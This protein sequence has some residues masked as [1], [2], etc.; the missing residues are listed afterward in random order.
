LGVCAWISRGIRLTRGS[1]LY[2]FHSVESPKGAVIPLKIGGQIGTYEITALLGKGGMGE[3]YRARDAKLKREVAIKILPEEFSRDADRV[4]RFQREAEVLASLN[5]A[6]IAAIY[7]VQEATGSRFLVLELVEGETLADRIARGP[8]PVEELLPIAKGISEALEAAHEKGVLHRDLKPANIKITPAGRVKVLDFGLAKMFGAEQAASAASNSPT[9]MSLSA[10][11]VILG[12]AAYMSPEQARGQAV[13]A[14]S[15][16][17]AFGCILYEMLTGQQTFSGET[18]TDILGGIVRVDPDWSVLPADTPPLLR[19]LLRQCLQKNRAARLH[20]IAD[21]RIQLEAASAEAP[22]AAAGATIKTGDID[23]RRP[24]G[25]IAVIAAMSLLLIGSAPLAY[26]YLSQT[27]DRAVMRFSFTMPDKVSYGVN[28]LAPF[29]SVSHDG[30]SVAF[31]ALQDGISRVW[32][33]PIDSL[34]PRLLPGTEGALAEFPFWSADDRHLGFFTPGKLKKVDINGGPAQVVCDV[35]AGFGGSWNRDNIIIFSDIVVKRVSSGG[36]IPEPI[37]SLDPKRHEVSHS[38]PAFLPDG[39]HFLF[40]SRTASLETYAVMAGSLN[41]KEIKLVMN[42]NSLVEYDSGHLLF[43][44]DGTLFAQRFDPE[45]QQFLG[46]PFSVAEQIRQN[47]N[48]GLA[49]FSVS[50]G[51]LAY[52]TGNPDGNRRLEWFDRSGKSLG[53]VGM[54]G[55]FRNPELSPDGKRIAVERIDIQTQNDDVWV[56]DVARGIPSRL[57]FDPGID[58]YPVWSPNGEQIAF[59]T[60]RKGTDNLYLT[61]STGGTEELLLKGAAIPRDWTKDN[62]F[63]V[64]GVGAGSQLMV[65]PLSGDRKTFPFLANSGFTYAQARV[66]P[67]GKWLAYYSNESG[68]N[69]IYVQNFPVPTAKFQ[70]STDG[71]VSPRWRRDGTEIFYVSPDNVLMAVSVRTT[72]KTVDPSKSEALFNIGPGPAGLVGYGTRQ[73]YDVTADGKRFLVNS[74]ITQATENPVAVVWNWLGAFSGK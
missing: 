58:M 56:F 9:L 22:P 20:H 71:G 57:T 6:N 13:D 46:D 68:R 45:K 59:G 35:A 49:T 52:R 2:T 40:L 14:Q 29:P 30:K 43:V 44:R 62:R 54:P 61:S 19:L 41:S 67:D 32:I 3:V 5:H 16:I 18:I 65:L 15:D 26:R 21:A 64:Y 8:I 36:G 38:L 28:S 73:Q 12:T 70:I 53:V 24:W 11:G 1:H 60:S 74:N 37:T 10:H 47:V 34:E 66:S 55:S 7:D 17:W 63:I 25:W 4:T 69:E 33:R 48:N 27:K 23:K 50:N 51:T 31:V 42:G 72:D 39:N